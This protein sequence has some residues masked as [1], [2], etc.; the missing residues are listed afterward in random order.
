MKSTMS[1]GTSKGSVKG[2]S[3]AEQC[4]SCPPSL[5][6]ARSRHTTG[7][8]PSSSFSSSQLAPGL[9]RHKRRDVLWGFA[10]AFGLL[11]HEE[12]A[13]ALPLAPLGP[14]KTGS[15][16]NTGLGIEEV[17]ER[18]TKSLK[19]GQYFVNASGLDTTI[20]ADDCQFK[21]PTNDVKGL[22]R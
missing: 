10:L 19:E 6:R 4:V 1:S 8:A 20:F 16:K 12:E 3:G 18:I 22:S 11:P 9:I 21:D 7:A 14:V 17:K 2:G 5:S 15:Q 13:R